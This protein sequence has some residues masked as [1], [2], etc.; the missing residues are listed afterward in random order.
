MIQRQAHGRGALGFAALLCLFAS[1]QTHALTTEIGDF[2]ISLNSRALFGGAIRLEDR[3]RETLGK[4]NAT[5]DLCPDDCISFT[6]DPGPNQRLVDAPGAFI[7][8]I[9]DDGNL[10]YDQGDFVSAQAR[11]ESDL[12]VQ[13]G[14]AVMK[15][16][17]IAFFDQVNNDFSET[18]FDTAFQPARAPRSGGVT[19]RVGTDIDLQEAF[20][21]YPFQLGDIYALVSVGE[22]R[23]RWG[24][25]TFVALGSLDQLNPPNENRLNFPGSEIASVFE[26]T[27]L[28]VISADLTATIGL[29][30]V[31][32]YDWEPA[33]PAAAGSFYSVNDI[34]GGGETAVIGLGQFSEDPNFVGGFKGTLPQLLT[35]TSLNV[36]V[37]STRGRPDEQGQFGGRLTW[38]AE[39]LNGGTEL[40]FYALNYHSRLPYASTI[41]TDRSCLRDSPLGLSVTDILGPGVNDILAGLGNL[42]PGVTLDNLSTEGGLAI[43]GPCGGGTGT[44]GVVPGENQ[45]P[46]P[47]GTLRPFLDYPEDIRLFGLAFNT[48]FGSWSLAGEYVYHP[49]LPLQ[50]SLADVIFAGL[51]P[52]LPAE[53]QNILIA[54]VP[55]ARTAAPDFVQTRFRKDPV[56][57]NDLIRGY[58][59]QKVHQLALTGIRVFSS[60]NWIGAD[61]IILLAEL[62]MTYIQDMPGLNELQFEGGG[63]NCT[64]F[65]PGADGTGTADGEPN[66]RRLNPTQSTDCF[67]DEFSTGYRLF[68]RPTYNNFLFGWTYTPIIGL[69]HDVYGISASP[70]QNFVE[71]EVEVLLGTDIEFAQGFQAQILYQGFF[72]T[73]N[74]RVSLLQDR[75][76]LKFSIEYNF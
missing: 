33:Q 35:S 28:A 66:A 21:S 56:E 12:S 23:V 41:A 36:P 2:D 39:D 68:I 53:D 5:P 47:I 73:G 65:S 37:S 31:Y 52:A 34:A 74:D 7:G 29:E 20:I 9:Y 63:P 45:E 11:F 22:Q 32:Q 60:S 17:G 3:A 43:L 15:V 61:Q 75:D 38:F 55:G 42:V 64:H 6:D 19:S 48:Q 16:S 26:P 50:V 30:L 27:G 1:A 24:E 62:G 71:G 51:Q 70:V 72:D 57:A 44:L 69:F 40:G 13:W 58:E 49:N 54:N 76:N 8:S 18:N 25:S 4:L 14:E 59:R 46:L 67:A 10:N